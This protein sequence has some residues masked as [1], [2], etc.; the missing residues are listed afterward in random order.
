MTTASISAPR[1]A[2][3]PKLRL[4]P[5]GHRQRSEQ[6]RAST[7]IMRAPRAPEPAAGA[8]AAEVIAEA[9]PTRFHAEA[10]VLVVGRDPSR[11]AATIDE[12]A[13]T[14]PSGTRFAHASALW[15]VLVLAGSSRM[16]ILSDDLVDVTS[17]SLM[18]MLSHRYPA[19]AVVALDDAPVQRVASH[20]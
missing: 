14:M 9:A 20:S 3:A 6:Q 10:S 17:A 5:S 4:L 12:F 13:D 7:R 1:L 18:R 11:L 16:V 19:L 8:G 15:E 2:G